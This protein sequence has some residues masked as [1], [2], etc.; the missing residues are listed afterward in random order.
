M[1]TVAIAGQHTTQQTIRHICS[2]ARLQCRCVCVHVRY[3]HD[4]V[5]MYSACTEVLGSCQINGNL[6]QIGLGRVGYWI[7]LRCAPATT[8][9]YSYN[10][11]CVCLCVHTYK[12][13]RHTYVCDWRRRWRYWSHR[14]YW[15]RWVLFHRLTEVMRVWFPDQN[16]RE[17]YTVLF[18][19]MPQICS[20][21]I[22]S[23]KR[24]YTTTICILYVCPWR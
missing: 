17:K 1:S 13:V 6:C 24:A 9:I 10:C 2:G 16:E 23:P 15:Y 22:E 20:F 14:V 18:G 7:I 4:C 5:N 21:V 11:I 3:T 8:F 19:I 12:S